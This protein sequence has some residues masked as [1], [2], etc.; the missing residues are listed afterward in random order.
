LD[1][2]T[3]RRSRTVGRVPAVAAATLLVLGIVVDRNSDEGVATDSDFSPSVADP[4]APPSVAEP[5]PS[6]GMVD[7]LGYEWSRISSDELAVG[8][9]IYGAGMIDLA[10]GG[11][12]LVAVGQ[13]PGSGEEHVAAVWTSVDGLTWSRVP[14]DEAVFGGED[15]SELRS[16]TVGGPGLVAVGLVHPVVDDVADGSIVQQPADAAVW[17]SVDGRN[18]SRVSHDEEVFGGE[19]D[20]VMSDVIVGGSGLLAVG[21]DHRGGYDLERDVWDEVGS[22]A[23]WTSVDGITWSRIPHDEAIFGGE[24]VQGMSSVTV[25][26]P[27][28]V[29]VGDD[30]FWHDG[31]WGQIQGYED[32]TRVAAV[33]TSVDGLTWSRVGHDE[34]VL[35][36]EGNQWMEDVMAAGAGVVAVGG[37]WSTAGHRA[38]VWTSDDGVTWSRVP[39]DEAVFGG[40]FDQVM[41]SVTPT[42]LGLV[43]VGG[44]DL[45]ASVWTSVDGITWSLDPWTARGGLGMNGVI[46]GG[47]GV[48]AVGDALYSAAVWVATAERTDN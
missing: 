7:S 13:M 3:S 40:E 43:A 17:T 45:Y 4:V 34:E 46:S 41:R 8:R 39:H 6:P 31:K 28:L 19:G 24:F 9:P 15:A 20:Q 12:G 36:G 16:V 10:V 42:E 22:A 30:G 18:W 29:A 11:P 35:G 25:G 32:A 38:A 26:G 21:H 27:G 47:P 33:W 48:V 44:G 14:H 2:L 37:D 23:V 5:V 1:G